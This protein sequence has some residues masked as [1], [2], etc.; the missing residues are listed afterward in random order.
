MQVDGYNFE[1]KEIFKLLQGAD[2]LAWQMNNH[3]RKIMPLGYD[4]STFLHDGF[5]VLREDQQMDMGFFTDNH[6]EQ[7][8]I[9]L[10]DYESTNGSIYENIRRD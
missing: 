3:I 8:V 4:D 10:D 9:D 5:R 7:W 1:R 6:I 2:I